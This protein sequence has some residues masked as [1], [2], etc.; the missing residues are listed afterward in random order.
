MK[1]LL[2][3][4]LLAVSLAAQQRDYLTVN[5]ADQIREAQ[6][7]NQRLSLYVTF[8]K[9]RLSQVDHWLAKEKAGRSILIHDALDDYANIVDAIDS[10]ADDA[11]QRHVDIKAGLAAVA[12]AE[13]EML[14]HLQK[15]QDGQPKDLS[16]YDF[17]LKQ[18]ID[19]T[20][21]SLDL[22]RED[23][24]ARAAAIAAN[25]AKE[26]KA[27][28]DA[29]TPAERDAKKA[30]EAKAEKEKKKA[31]TLLRPGETLDPQNPQKDP[32]E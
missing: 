30:E 7:P 27:L 23:P 15:I 16:R 11:L 4:A 21:D 29:M 9:Q 28:R 3:C 19:G 10:V 20:N 17:V 14:L 31:P 25:Q 18:S 32:Q 2:F 12:T 8:A 6:E 24:A 22:A 13:S 26:K 1:I 5:E